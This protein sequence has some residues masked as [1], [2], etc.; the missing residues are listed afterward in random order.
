M[1]SHCF[2]FS[3]SLLFFLGVGRQGA[4]RVSFSPGCPQ[5][6]CVAE[7]DLKFLILLPPPPNCW[8]Y[9]CVTPGSDSVVLWIKPMAVC[10]LGKQSV[11]WATSPPCPVFSINPTLD[12]RARFFFHLWPE[13]TGFWVHRLFLFHPKIPLHRKQTVWWK[14]PETKIS[15]LTVLKEGDSELA[16]SPREEWCIV[17]IGSNT[18]PLSSLNSHTHR[19]SCLLKAFTINLSVIWCYSE[20][21]RKSPVN[22]HSIWP[23]AIDWGHNN[24]GGDIEMLI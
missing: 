23:K 11:N 5:T 6:Y 18:M 19:H 10:M 3:P 14:D 2:S 17:L 1:P 22:F 8:N 15:P 21:H 4:D 20:L 13:K 12:L 9:K 16:L 24:E 7:N